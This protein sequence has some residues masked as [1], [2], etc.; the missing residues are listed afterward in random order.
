MNTKR[1]ILILLPVLMMLSVGLVALY[2]VMYGLPGGEGRLERHVRMWKRGDFKGYERVFSNPERFEEVILLNYLKGE[3]TLSCEVSQGKLLCEGF[4][5]MILKEEGGKYRILSF[6]YAVDS[7]FSLSLMNKRVPDWRSKVKVMGYYK[8]LEVCVGQIRG[9]TSLDSLYLEKKAYE[10]DLKVL[11][12]LEGRELNARFYEIFE[13]RFLSGHTC[14]EGGDFLSAHRKFSRVVGVKDKVLARLSS[15][16]SR[17][18]G[19]IK[20]LSEELGK[21]LKASRD[22]LAMAFYKRGL[23]YYSKGDLE[24]ARIFFKRA[25]KIEPDFEQARKALERVQSLLEK[26]F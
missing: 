2:F 14:L 18:E 10:N 22:P 3:F 8:A 11:D 19:A 16:R 13:E 21:R 7:S 1:L 4:T 25:L 6:V 12:R 26:G 9:R 15:H 23:E 24:S 5:P 17:V 20:A